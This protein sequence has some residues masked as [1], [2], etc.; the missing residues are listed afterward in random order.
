MDC[1]KERFIDKYFGRNFDYSEYFTLI[2]EKYIVWNFIFL[3]N[4]N[5][6]DLSFLKRVYN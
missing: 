5:I 2:A 6:G 3:H 4:L 1:D